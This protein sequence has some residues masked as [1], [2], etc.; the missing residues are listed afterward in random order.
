MLLEQVFFE[1]QDSI[2][3]LVADIARILIVELESKEL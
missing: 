2:I 1:I 3:I